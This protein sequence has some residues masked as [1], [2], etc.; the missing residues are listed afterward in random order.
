MHPTPMVPS[1]SASNVPRNAHVFFL[2]RDHAL[3][4]VPAEAQITS[5][6]AILD[7]R[8]GTEPYQSLELVP[9]QL[10][11]NA[12]YTVEGNLYALKPPPPSQTFGVF[13]TGTRDDDTPP[14]LAVVS[15]VDYPKPSGPMSSCASL[16]DVV[17]RVQ[18]TDE[19]PA[20]IAVFA[21]IGAMPAEPPLVD[22]VPIGPGGRIAFDVPSS[23]GVDVAN[24]AARERDLRSK[25][26]ALMAVDVAGNRSEVVVL[27]SQKK[28][29]AFKHA[30]FG[31]APPGP[32]VAPSSAPAPPPV[33]SA[34]ASSSPAP[35]LPP[36]SASAAP[37]AS[38]SPP[39]VERKSSG[40]G[41]DLPGTAWAG[42]AGLA[43]A[44]AAVL[45]L[46]R[47]RRR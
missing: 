24:A 43:L 5:S 17:V 25:T 29:P 40:C 34:P 8:V 46:L 10:A 13:R 7:R 33:T 31:G 12:A 27:P 4:T 21:W 20:F 42:D 30:I 44:G 11:P 3:S 14:R 19:S 28:L 23:P 39:P 35:P 36:S 22:S 26:L 9:P 6:G 37:S 2:G 38:P 47:R 18:V 1:A 45:G 32:S 41:C 15:G 16:P